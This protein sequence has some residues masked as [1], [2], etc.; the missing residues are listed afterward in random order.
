VRVVIPETFARLEKKSPQEKGVGGRYASHKET[1]K[2]LGMLV[3]EESRR[4]EC[5]HHCANLCWITL[6]K[7]A[8][9]LHV[10]VR[11]EKGRSQKKRTNGGRKFVLRADL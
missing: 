5:F 7:K 6:H 8:R 11:E 10:T 2:G 4:G 1:R 3:T 9:E